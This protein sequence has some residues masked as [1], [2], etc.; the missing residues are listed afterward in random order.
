MLTDII[1]N[2]MDYNKGH[3]L[4]TEDTEVHRGTQSCLYSHSLCSSVSSVVDFFAIYYRYTFNIV[5]S[6]R[7]PTC[8]HLA[9]SSHTCDKKRF[10]APYVR[11]HLSI[12]QSP[13][14][15]WMYRSAPFLPFSQAA[16]CSQDMNP[17]HTELARS[18]CQTGCQEC[19][20]YPMHPHLW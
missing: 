12:H 8:W 20:Q 7:T 2:P 9:P 18:P 6:G 13:I 19:L 16:I 10:Q 15:T 5:S 17:T 11:T 1:Q 3:I 4:T 14:A